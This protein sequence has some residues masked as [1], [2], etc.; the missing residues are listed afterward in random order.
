MPDPTRNTAEELTTT[1]SEEQRYILDR[2]LHSL[3]AASKHTLRQYRRVSAQFLA[4][5]QLDGIDLAEATAAT[6]EDFLFEMGSLSPAS[7]RAYL[8]ILS[9]LYDYLIVQGAASSN[10]PLLYRKSAK[11]RLK[12]KHDAAT[13]VIGPREF[14]LV[15]EA[16][17]KRGTAQGHPERNVERDVA[18]LHVLFGSGIRRAELVGLNVQSHDAKSGTLMVR[19]KGNKVRRAAILVEAEEVL[20]HYESHVRPEYAPAESENAMFLEGQPGKA[21][22]ISYDQVGYMVRRSF[23]DAGVI[24]AG[25]DSGTHVLRRSHA[26]LL[27]RTMRNPKVVQAQLGHA[28]ITT[29][30]RYI[31]LADDEHIEQIRD[32]VGIRTDD[33]TS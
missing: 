8:S 7:E 28:S 22:R 33:E 17:R 5:L 11:G 16:R 12:R 19:G 1:L 2:F 27:Q 4:H 13:S 31:K 29:T 26:T 21:R 25:G 9:G 14:A 3:G 6:V 18:I 15:V 10:P 30:D 20:K 24:V 23:R 32:H